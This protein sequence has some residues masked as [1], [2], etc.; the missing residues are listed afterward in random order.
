MIHEM[1][2]PLMEETT[3][4]EL[5]VKPDPALN[6][7]LLPGAH[8]FAAASS[9]VQYRSCIVNVLARARS[10]GEAESA[11]LREAMVDST[12]SLSVSILC[13]SWQT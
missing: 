13:G 9:P 8:S 4:Q 2:S 11:S 7:A 3:D 10:G 6:P 12:F 5:C 1:H